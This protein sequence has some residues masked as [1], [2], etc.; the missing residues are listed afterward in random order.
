MGDRSRGVDC[1][2]ELRGSQTDVGLQEPQCRSYAF[3]G[4]ACYSGDG[5]TADTT[6]YLLLQQD[7]TNSVIRDPPH[8]CD[9]GREK[10]NEHFQ[11]IPEALELIKSVYSYYAVHG[12]KIFGC[13]KIAESLGVDWKQLH[14]IF[15]IRFVESEYVAITTFLHDYPVVVIDFQR[16]IE[17][18]KDDATMDVAKVKHWLRRMLQFKFV[19]VCLILIDIDKS[20]K[21]FS[22][23]TFAVRREPGYGAPDLPSKVLRLSAAVHCWLL[24]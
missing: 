16:T 1:H 8:C 22:K 20:L 13:M 19:A 21:I 18:A 2:K 12:K 15:P 6:K 24:G 17:A 10:M 23:A 4:E 9:I 3:D 14:Y 5:T 7:V 11:Y